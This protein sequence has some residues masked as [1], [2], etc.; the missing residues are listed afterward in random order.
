MKKLMKS[1]VLLAP[2]AVLTSCEGGKNG[3]NGEMKGHFD[4]E[5]TIKFSQAYGQKYQPTLQAMIDDFKE[6]EPNV[7]INLEDG[8]ISGNYDTIHTNTCNDMKTGEYGDLVIAYAD[9]VADYMDYG[10][11]VQLDPYINNPEYG[12]TE[13]HTRSMLGGML[14][15][16]DD[17]FKE[18]GTL[19]G[20]QKARLVLLKLVKQIN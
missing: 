13:E 15:H 18:I 14:F 7:V 10:K 19:S 6:K 9:H 8:W 11:A 2:L 1:L 4:H 17:V 12:F 20:G 3:G 5:V 16:G